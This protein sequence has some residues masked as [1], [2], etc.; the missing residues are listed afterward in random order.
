MK[1]SSLAALYLTTL[2]TCLAIDLTWL[3]V[4]AKSFYTKHLGFLMS[5]NP[6]LLVGLLFYLLFTVGLLTFVVLPALETQSF[7]KALSLGFFFG[8]VVYSAYD[9]TNQAIVKDWPLIVTIVDMLWGATLSCVVSGCSFYVARW[10][11]LK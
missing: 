10:L 8:L 7:G 1:C 2:L 6:N 9:L 4:V 3:T 11:T 5:S